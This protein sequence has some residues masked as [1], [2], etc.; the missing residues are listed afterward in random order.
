MKE[1][2]RQLQNCQSDMGDRGLVLCRKGS[3]VRE[4]LSP[5]SSRAARASLDARPFVIKSLLK[6]KHLL[7]CNFPFDL[8]QFQGYC[9]EY[10]PTKSLLASNLECAW[11]RACVFCTCEFGGFA[12]ER[13]FP[14]DDKG[15][16]YATIP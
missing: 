13:V 15:A 2:I 8:E 7:Q 11:L 3:Q 6:P 14:N 10:Y 1:W 4:V 5:Q 16:M 12:F 9:C